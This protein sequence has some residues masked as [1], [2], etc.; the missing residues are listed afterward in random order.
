[1]SKPYTV[2]IDDAPCEHCGRGITYTIVGPDGV[3]IGE[4][5][6]DAEGAVEASERAGQL[7]AAY[8]LGQRNPAPPL[9]IPAA[10]AEYEAGRRYPLH[11]LRLDLQSRWNVLYLTP[12]TI[13]EMAIVGEDLVVVFEQPIQIDEIPF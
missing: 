3:A 9:E 1:M 12:P 5:W 8:A 2:I 10:P 7:N 11:N 4:S 6:T 13:K